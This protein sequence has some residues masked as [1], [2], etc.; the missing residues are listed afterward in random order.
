MPA[1]T[2]PP[3]ILELARVFDTLPDAA[4]VSY[5]V[6]EVITGL[7]ARTLRRHPQLPRVRLSRKRFALNVGN[8]RALLRGDTAA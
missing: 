6:G 7:S 5:S 8:L 2:I 3:K 1:K 4:A